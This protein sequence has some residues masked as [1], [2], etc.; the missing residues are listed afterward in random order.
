VDFW[1][2]VISPEFREWNEKWAAM[3]YEQKV[4]YAKKL[5]VKWEHDDD[6][7]TDLMRI[8]PAVRAKEGI[9]KYKEQYQTR[10]Q[11][12]DLRSS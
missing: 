9:K 5:G 11:R 2:E 6:P 12:A 1:N 3:S 4:K 10:A 7:R 8:A